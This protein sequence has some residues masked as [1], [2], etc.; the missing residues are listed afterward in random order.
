[1][2]LEKIKFTQSIRERDDSH[3]LLIGLTNSVFRNGLILF[4]EF[5]FV[6]R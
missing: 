5:F 2:L 3:Y 1:M 4:V 6:L